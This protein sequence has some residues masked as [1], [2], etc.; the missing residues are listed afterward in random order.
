VLID[1]PPMLAVSDVLPLLGVVDGVIVVARLGVTTTVAAQRLG[2]QLRRLPDVP[3]LG[4]VVNNVAK[5][6]VRDRGYG[7]ASPAGPAP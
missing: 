1:C 2:E 3:V 7:F 6:Y 5:R 4:V